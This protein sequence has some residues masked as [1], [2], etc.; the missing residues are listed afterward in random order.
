MEANVEIRT[1]GEV[2]SGMLD[3][4]QKKKTGKEQQHGSGNLKGRG[5]RIEAQASNSGN[6]QTLI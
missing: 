4:L 2:K 3:Q 6:G 5:E 1:T